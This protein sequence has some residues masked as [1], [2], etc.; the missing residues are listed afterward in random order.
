MMMMIRM[1]MR[2]MIILLP[3]SVQDEDPRTDR[4]FEPTLKMVSF[5]FDLSS[6]LLE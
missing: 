2:R 6:Y 4:S 5:G 3:G 1:M